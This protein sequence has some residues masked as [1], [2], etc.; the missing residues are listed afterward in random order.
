MVF[1][2]ECLDRTD[3]YSNALNRRITASLL[4]L[5]ISNHDNNFGHFGKFRDEKNGGDGDGL[6]ACLF[7]TCIGI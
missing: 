6:I 1:A 2:C 4:A 3:V 5:R 7:G